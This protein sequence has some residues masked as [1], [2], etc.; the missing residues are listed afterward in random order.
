MQRVPAGSFRWAWGRRSARSLHRT[1]QPLPDIEPIPSYPCD[2]RPLN[3]IPTSCLSFRR[4]L[5]VTLRLPAQWRILLYYGPAGLSQTFE[6]LRLR[7][8]LCDDYFQPMLLASVD[9]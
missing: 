9:G 3:G 5:L 2:G 1:R 6:S 7:K 8:A 4:F